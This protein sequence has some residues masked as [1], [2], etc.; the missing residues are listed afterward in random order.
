ML[1]RIQNGSVFQDP[2]GTVARS[3]GK[4]WGTKICDA[5]FQ[6]LA[7]SKIFTSLLKSQPLRVQLPQPA[8]LGED[9]PTMILYEPVTFFGHRPQC[10]KVHSLLLRLLPLV[11]TVKLGRC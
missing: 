6:D 9:M 10:V 4:G 5:A 3:R 2:G 7:L 8:T 11:D 1:A